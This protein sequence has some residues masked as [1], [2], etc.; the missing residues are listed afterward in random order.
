MYLNN[1]D[2]NHNGL[3]LTASATA[4]R[5]AVKYSTAVEGWL[6]KAANTVALAAPSSAVT[7]T[8]LDT[9]I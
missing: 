6:K 5:P 1:S 9:Y 4:T 7:L 8:S 3:K 2:S